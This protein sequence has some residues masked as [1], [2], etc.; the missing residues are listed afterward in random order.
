MGDIV[1]KLILFDF[2]GVLADTRELAIQQVELLR[3]NKVFERLPSVEDVGHFGELYQGRLREALLRFGL[4]SD[5]SRAFFD[6]HAALMRSLGDKVEMFNYIPELLQQLPPNSY[7]IITSAET[8]LVKSV[9]ER[10]NIQTENVTIL[11][12]E[13]RVSKA[14]KVRSLLSHKCLTKKDVIY[15][16]DMESDVLYMDEIDVECIAVSYGYHPYNILLNTNATK[17]LQSPEELYN[18]FI[19]GN[20]LATIQ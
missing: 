15:V 12:H 14:E 18:F 16:G 3:K 7:A 2:D 1:K 10:N 5:E 4:D 6:S 20:I 8:A 17:I 19:H 11:G 9:L 13:L